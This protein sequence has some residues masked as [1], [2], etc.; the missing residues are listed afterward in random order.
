MGHPRRSPAP[1]PGA[2]PGAPLAVGASVSPGPHHPS[3]HI[4][5]LVI[6]VAA[7]AILLASAV[8]PWATA[9]AADGGGTRGGTRGVG[10]VLYLPLLLVAAPFV[11]GGL[12]AVGRRVP[13]LVPLLTALPGVVVAFHIDDVVTSSGTDAV[14]VEGPGPWVLTAAVATL[15]L[16]LALDEV[17]WPSAPVDVTTSAAVVAA[18]GVALAYVLPV[19][20]MTHANERYPE[21]V[22]GWHL[23]GGVF[24]WLLTAAGLVVATMLVRRVGPVPGWLRTAAVATPPAGLVL[25][26]ADVAARGGSPRPG[27]GGLL[28]A[29]STVALVTSAVIG[30]WRWRDGRRPTTKPE[31]GSTA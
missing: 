30:P 28:L 18:V 6:F 31:R 23:R 3:V 1:N 19:A 14:F 15:A 12:R 10:A 27:S 11:A 25:A 13:S 17:A 29:A 24:A 5:A 26:V 20:R 16:S 4:V 7:V 9:P 21:V 22:R 8:V 2:G